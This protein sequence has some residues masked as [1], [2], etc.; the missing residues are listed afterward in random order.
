MLT[1]EPASWTS[2]NYHRIALPFA[3]LRAHPKVPVYVFNRLPG[4][5]LLT[6]QAKKAAGVRLVMDLDDYW[7]LPP[8][9]YLAASWNASGLPGKLVMALRLADVVMVTTETLAAQVREINPSVVIVPNA[10][11]FDSGQFTR[12]PTEGGSTFVYAAGASHRPDVLPVADALNRVDLTLAGVQG[13]HAEWVTIRGML[14]RCLTAEARPVQEYMGLYDGHAVAIAPLVDD[15]FNR[16][17][18]NLKALEA[19]ARGIPLIASPVAPYAGMPGVLHAASPAEWTAQM[20]RCRHSPG[21]AADAG[22]ALAEHVRTH[23]SLA[24]SN[25]IRRQVLESLS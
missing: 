1:V 25:R 14:P 3:H 21:M 6:L 15:L 22:A 18:S 19:G 7:Q 5:D 10:L 8:A 12:G 23:F 9:H 4:W 16:C 13:G 11:P 20:D 2:C 17:K 24:A